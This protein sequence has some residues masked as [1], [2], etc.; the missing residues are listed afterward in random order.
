MLDPYQ[1]SLI[2]TSSPFHSGRGESNKVANKKFKTDKPKG[3]SAGLLQPWHQED[4]MLF[5]NF[6]KNKER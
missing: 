5:C 3:L 2:S 1:I 4:L 6:T